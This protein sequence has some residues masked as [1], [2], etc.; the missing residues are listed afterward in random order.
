MSSYVPAELRRFVARR[1]RHVCEYCLIHEDDTFFGCEIEH[2]I[3]EKHGGRTVRSNLAWACAACNRN[4]GT[5]IAS[6]SPV[7][8]ALCRL[9]N[10][11]TDRWSDHLRLRGHHILGI[12]EVGKVTVLLLDLNAPDRVLERR[13]LGAVGRYPGAETLKWMGESQD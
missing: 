1:A 8:R 13:M 9:F 12:T 10:P 2:V 5:D 4:K 3:S 7:S 6:I 11:R